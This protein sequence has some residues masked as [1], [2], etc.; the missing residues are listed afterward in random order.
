MNRQAFA[1]TFVANCSV[2]TAL[3]VLVDGTKWYNTTVPSDVGY[4]Y[5]RPFNTRWTEYKIAVYD[6]IAS[7][8]K[9]D[10]AKLDSVESVQIVFNAAQP[11]V[12]DSV[13]VQDTQKVTVSV[14]YWGVSLE[15][16]TDRLGFRV[17]GLGLSKVVNPSYS[18]TY[19]GT[20]YSATTGY[21]YDVAQITAASAGT[22]TVV[23]RAFGLG[24]LITD[25]Y[26]IESSG[27]ITL[28][29]SVMKTNGSAYANEVLMQFNYDV[30][31]MVSDYFVESDKPL[32]SFEGLR[33]LMAPTQDDCVNI[34]DAEENIG[35]DLS[36]GATYFSR[37]MSQVTDIDNS[38][39]AIYGS[40]GDVITIAP[41]NNTDNM[42]IEYSG[43]TKS[44]S[45]NSRLLFK[46]DSITDC[47]AYIKLYGS[48]G[49]VY[50]FTFNETG[51]YSV[52]LSSVSVSIISLHIGATKTT[53]DSRLVIDW[54][55]LRDSPT[56]FDNPMEKPAIITVHIPY[57]VEGFDSGAAVGWTGTDYY[58]NASD[59]FT[60]GV[61]SG[62]LVM[63]GAYPT[64]GKVNKISLDGIAVDTTKYPRFYM[65]YYYVPG[66]Q[67]DASVVFRYYR[68][69]GTN[70]TLTEALSTAQGAHE[71]SLSN[72]NSIM[73]NGWITSITVQ[74]TKSGNGV[75]SYQLWLDEIVVNDGSNDFLVVPRETSVHE[76]FR[77]VTDWSVAGA[78]ELLVVNN[79][80][81][82]FSSPTGITNYSKAVPLTVSASSYLEYS[83]T[84]GS[85]SSF[86]PSLVL[87]NGTTVGVVRLGPGAIPTGQYILSLSNLTGNDVDKLLIQCTSGWV[88]MDYLR[89]AEYA[90]ACV[91]CTTIGSWATSGCTAI[92]GGSSTTVMVPE[93]GAWTA[94]TVLP[95]AMRVNVYDTLQI[96]YEVDGFAT[97]DNNPKMWVYGAS[98]ATPTGDTPFPFQPFI[99]DGAVHVLCVDLRQAFGESGTFE[100]MVIGSDVGTSGGYNVT[101]F[102]VNV[103]SSHNDWT[104]VY[105]GSGYYSTISDGAGVMSIQAW[106]TTDGTR[107]GVGGKHTVG[108]PA[109][110]VGDLYIRYSTTSSSNLFLEAYFTVD[111]AK[112]AITLPASSTERVATIDL[113]KTLSLVG[114]EWISDF[115]ITLNWTTSTGEFLRAD[116]QSIE[117]LGTPYEATTL[118]E[119]FTGA[120]L[121]LCQCGR[122]AL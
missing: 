45:A 100:K 83:I 16:T 119:A 56:V 106:A 32:V 86:T 120:W 8:A 99:S 116:I 90:G 31:Q 28:Q 12:I 20:N 6:I 37:D 82:L 117:L 61:N 59:F 65:K 15:W 79:E 10:G 73:S 11:G 27:H 58:T 57:V 71:L 44:P 25:T 34:D 98:G 67:M 18:V 74:T 97:G 1:V 51:T 43:F 87:G 68:S 33:Y 46:V 50:T 109:S 121:D 60:W 84:A 40:D 69:D 81:G 72:L 36:A 26:V 103:L 104:K 102:G 75:G 30:S 4:S 17:T 114:T 66:P 113:S 52:S 94:T 22:T 107:D 19:R 92:V 80:L 55:G 91:S 108:M 76:S 105:C 2:T 5:V 35:T 70:T 77:D 64:T 21:W 42:W 93:S 9:N 88:D 7:M 3:K 39:K 89:V 53:P 41:Q 49:P 63:Q 96:T 85:A 47:D 62:N 48:L 118:L 111:G 54:L 115:G 110:L 78:G 112:R 23:E 14:P 101:L 29:R 122:Q 95:C 24:L 13:T 38:Y